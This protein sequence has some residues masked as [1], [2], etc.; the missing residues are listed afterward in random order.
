MLWINSLQ[1][2]PIKSGEN[3]EVRLSVVC[4]ND[5]PNITAV[6]FQKWARYLTAEEK[7]GGLQKEEAPFR[8][9]GDKVSFPLLCI[10]ELSS[11]FKSLQPIVENE[12]L[13]KTGEASI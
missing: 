11:Q 3:S 5:D 8:P 1:L 7:R 9:T 2:L 12:E 10:G 13:K 4:R 6:V